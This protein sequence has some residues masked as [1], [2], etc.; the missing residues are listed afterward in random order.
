M[1]LVYLFS[2]LGIILIVATIMTYN[3]KSNSTN[4]FILFLISLLSLIFFILVEIVLAIKYGR[5][6]GVS[7]NDLYYF[8]SRS[9][10]SSDMLLD[11]DVVIRLFRYL[12]YD[13]HLT[14]HLIFWCFVWYTYT[15]EA[16]WEES[17]ERIR[18]NFKKRRD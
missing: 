2:F 6:Y 14:G 12:I 8:F 13:A 1:S 9:Y 18:D 10:I 7:I 11:D 17:L 5:Y 15:K 4:Y 3:K 16:Y